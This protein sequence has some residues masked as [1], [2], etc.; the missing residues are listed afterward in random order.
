MLEPGNSNRTVCCFII[1]QFAYYLHFG[2]GMRKHINKVVND[3]IQPVTHQI[4]QCFDQF[5]T[6]CQIQNLVIGI[7]DIAAV[8]PELLAQ[9]F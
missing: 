2:A 5:A 3:N 9:Q 7:F 8:A 4:G 6:G 1:G